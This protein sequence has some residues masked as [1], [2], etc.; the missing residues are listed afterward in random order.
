MSTPRL[1]PADSTNSLFHDRPVLD[2]DR[3]FV[4]KD[5]AHM[6]TFYK[7]SA[8]SSALTGTTEKQISFFQERAFQSQPMV[9]H[10]RTEILNDWILPVF[11]ICFSI[12]SW[13]LVS[14]R[15]RFNHVVK[16]TYSKQQ[17]GFLIREGGGSYDLI[18]LSLG[19]VFVTVLALLMYQ[20]TEPITGSSWPVGSRLPFFLI[21]AGGII[22]WLL[23]RLALIRILGWTFKNFEITSQYLMNSMAFHFIMGIILLP[24]LV[25]SIYTFIPAFL[26]LSLGIA[27]ILFILRLFRGIIIGLSD[28]NFSIFY[29]FFYLCTVEILPVLVI[30]KIAKDNL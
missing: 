11:L 25:I 26:Y 8:Q 23:V 27:G 22:A 5:F 20:A 15:K 9:A 3:P 18:N 29:L 10:E 14:Y 30:V 19:F 6:I 28:T 2:S 1:L 13:I 21:T 4:A 17:L 16:A 24:F 12:L 7:D